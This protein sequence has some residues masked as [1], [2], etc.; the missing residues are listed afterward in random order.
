MLLKSGIALNNCF[1]LDSV[2]TEC[3]I[4]QETGSTAFIK[5]SNNV[6][7]MTTLK[8]VEALNNYIAHPDDG[9]DTTGW[10]KRI[11]GENNLPALDFN[12]EWNGTEWVTVEN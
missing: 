1:Y 8:V 4:T 3:G 5:V 11:V 6:E 2:A 9:I 12:T 7:D 10:C